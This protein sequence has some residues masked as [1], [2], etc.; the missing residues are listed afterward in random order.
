LS[1]KNST[2]EEHHEC[3]ERSE[4]CEGSQTK[5][6]S[7]TH[8]LRPERSDGDAPATRAAWLRRRSVNAARRKTFPAEEKFEE[9]LSRLITE[10]RSES[11]C[12][13]GKQAERH[14]T[15]RS[16]SHT[17]KN[18]FWCAH[19]SNTKCHC[20]KFYDVVTSHRTRDAIRFKFV[21]SITDRSD[22][23]NF[24]IIELKRQH[25]NASIMITEANRIEE[26]DSEAWGNKITDE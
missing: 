6:Q 20:K 16:W 8:K 26:R 3:P 13:L 11:M 7:D 22:Q 19:A 10:E 18:I 23:K 4:G 17:S 25:L 2:G 14:E 12:C 21:T 24:L 9:K 15:Q 5:S 1:K